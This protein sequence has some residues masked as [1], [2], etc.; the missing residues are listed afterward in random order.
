MPA[1]RARVATVV[2]T[3][4]VRANPATVVSQNVSWARARPMPGHFGGSRSLTSAALTL[5]LPNASPRS[6]NA[7]MYEPVR[8]RRDEQERRQRE[9]EVAG[10]NQDGLAA[11]AV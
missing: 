10:E 4:P 5:L 1:T 6:V 8:A 3:A 11:Q 2:N 7:A 9:G